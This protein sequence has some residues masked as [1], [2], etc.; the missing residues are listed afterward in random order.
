MSVTAGSE[1]GGLRSA[2]SQGSDVI[3]SGPRP[4]GRLPATP[5]AAS[6]LPHSEARPLTFRRPHWL[7]GRPMG[8]REARARAPRP[9]RQLSRGL[10]R[11]LPGLAEAA[12]LCPR[13]A[14]VRP[15]VV[16][17]PASTDHAPSGGSE[18]SPAGGESVGAEPSD[19]AA[20]PCRPSDGLGE[21]QRPAA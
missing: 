6:P 9:G 7:R 21:G 11:A 8:R 12:H 2:G 16:E 18:A 14:A 20:S 13:P 10:S 17:A 15:K 19:G 3:G 1:P 4:G 5:R